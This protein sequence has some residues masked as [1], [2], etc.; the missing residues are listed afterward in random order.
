[1]GLFDRLIPIIRPMTVSVSPHSS[2]SLGA[3]QHLTRKLVIRIVGLLALISIVGIGTAAQRP[4]TNSSSNK[5]A[6]K[7]TATIN[8]GKSTTDNFAAETA[9]PAKVDNS[10]SSTS[11]TH[12]ST[13]GNASNAASGSYQVSVNG[14]SIDVPQNGTSKQVITSPGGTTTVT[15]TNSKSGDGTTH[16][17]SSTMMHTRTTNSGASLNTSVEQNYE[18]P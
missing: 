9:V 11:N 12:V 3:H 13:S 2:G 8:L 17:S 16:S 4:D 10:V 5:R 1:M 7:T 15:V 6:Q 14:Q 18:S